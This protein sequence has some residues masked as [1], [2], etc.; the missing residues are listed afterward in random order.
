MTPSGIE[1]ATFRLVAQTKYATACPNTGNKGL[2]VYRAKVKDKSDVF[3][4]RKLFDI[5]VPG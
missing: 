2:E 4:F 3:V 1:P 5:D